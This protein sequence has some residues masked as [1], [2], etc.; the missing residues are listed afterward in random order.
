MPLVIKELK[1]SVKD[2]PILDGVNLTV[3]KGEIHIV[4]GP[5]GGGKS[6]LAN[7]LMG[8]PKYTVTDGTVTLDGNDIT[9]ASPEAR[10]KLGLFLSMQYP[11]E[12]EGVAISHFL[13]TAKEALTGKKIPPLPF[14]KDLVEAAKKLGLEKDALARGLN[15]GFSG[16][17]KKRLEMLQLCTLEP[18]YAILDETDSGLD[19]D[20]L[21]VIGEAIQTFHT[22][23]NALILITHYS[24]ILDYVKPDKVHILKHGVIVKSGGAELVHEIETKGYGDKT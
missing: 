13:R 11:P 17:E 4:M 23:E 19:V 6:S 8:H 16:G 18:T 24:R 5:N 21:K 9:S 10:A 15:V 22:K 14:H 7:T 20:G 3:Q 1:V 12:I 2:T